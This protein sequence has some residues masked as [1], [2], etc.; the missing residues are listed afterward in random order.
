[1]KRLLFSLLLTIP[2]ILNADTPTN[3]SISV[4]G[5]VA[6][7]EFS[8]EDPCE[9]DR[10]EIVGSAGGKFSRLE[11]VEVS[12]RDTL[13][14]GSRIKRKS[15]TGPGRAGIQCIGNCSSG[16]HSVQLVFEAKRIL[17][18][19]IKITITDG[20]AHF[21]F[22]SV[23][24]TV[25]GPATLLQQSDLYIDRPLIQLNLHGHEV[26]ILTA[27]EHPE[28]INWLSDRSS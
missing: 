12:K 24:N 26:E 20:H 14:T 5:P 18:E 3:Y 8:C 10:Q 13:I 1:M 28:K 23:V 21:V 7:L 2:G 22:Y 27:M 6:E 16:Q 15:G 4:S 9:L 11:T 19:G 17:R 25:K